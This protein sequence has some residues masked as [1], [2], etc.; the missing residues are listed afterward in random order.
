MLPPFITLS[1]VLLLTRQ[2]TRFAS[3]E[4]EKF[5]IISDSGL[6]TSSGSSN[7]NKDAQIENSNYNLLGNTLHSDMKIY[8]EKD[9]I[10]IPAHRMI[11]GTASAV[12]ETLVYGGNSLSG[13]ITLTVKDFS[14]DDFVEVKYSL[15]N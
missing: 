5:K 10:T 8:V 6:Y 11:I 2:R 15:C 1:S 3:S 13:Q 4:M 12:L 7:N 9:D 14:A